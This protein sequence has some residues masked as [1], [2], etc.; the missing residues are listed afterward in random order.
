MTKKLISLLALSA[1]ATSAFAD[2][3]GEKAAIVI[4]Y[5]APFLIG[6]PVQVNLSHLEDAGTPAP[7]IMAPIGTMNIAKDKEVTSSDDFPIIGDLSY[8]TDGDK[9]SEEGYFVEPQVS[10]GSRL[11]SKSL[12]QSTAF[13]CGISTLKNVRTTTSS[14]RSRMMKRSRQA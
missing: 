10:S 5:P 6:T 2:H 3:H 13:R 11:T 8:A 9:E 1:L 12:R 7:I 4:D 14:C